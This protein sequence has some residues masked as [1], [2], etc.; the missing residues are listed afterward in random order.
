[1]PS[2]QATRN[3]ALAGALAAAAA[4]K[5]KERAAET[6]PISPQPSVTATNDTSPPDLGEASVIGDGRRLHV[7]ATAD[8]RPCVATDSLY[9]RVGNRVDRF[10]HAAKSLQYTLTASFAA[11]PE[12]TARGDT[13]VWIENGFARTWSLT[14][15]G[16]V[17]DAS[18]VPL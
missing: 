2:R 6:I 11:A 13:I 4:C 1:M 14:S 18:S 12:W 9:V 5:R 17:R 16:E 7:V 8:K 3:L 10:G 15:G